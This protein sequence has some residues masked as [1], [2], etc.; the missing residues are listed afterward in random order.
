MFEGLS[1]HG[2]SAGEDLSSEKGWVCICLVRLE[3]ELTFCGSLV[4]TLGV[5]CHANL[6]SEQNGLLQKVRRVLYSTSEEAF[7]KLSDYHSESSC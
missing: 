1:G 4:L 3:R 7:W 6:C 2:L 5:Y